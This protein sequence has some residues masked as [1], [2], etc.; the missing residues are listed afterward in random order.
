[1]KV[2]PMKSRNSFK[3]RALRAWARM[4]EGVKLVTGVATTCWVPTLWFCIT[5]RKAL[6]FLLTLCCEILGTLVGVLLYAFRA[7]YRMPSCV[8]VTRTPRVPA[9]AKRLPTKR[10]A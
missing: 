8:P 6:P 5:L 4:S 2:V 10:A 1:M 9:A 7:T 3:C